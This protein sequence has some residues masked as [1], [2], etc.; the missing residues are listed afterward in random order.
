MTDPLTSLTREAADLRRQARERVFRV[1]LQ[2]GDPAWR[3]RSADRERDAAQDRLERKRAQFTAMAP[4]L[5]EEARRALF[6]LTRMN[7]PHA[8]RDPLRE[9]TQWEAAEHAAKEVKTDAQAVKVIATGLAQFGRDP[10][11]GAIAGAVAMK[12]H[13]QGWAEALDRYLASTL[14]Q[15]RGGRAA[16]ERLE[17]LEKAAAGEGLPPVLGDDLPSAQEM[18]GARWPSSAA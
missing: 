16:L 6:D 14:G 7:A 11:A 1:A 17:V 18:L 8:R 10:M 12:A 9:A 2:E 3:R 5:A 15:T 4:D 13:R